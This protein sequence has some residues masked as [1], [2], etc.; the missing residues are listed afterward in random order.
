MEG[1]EF[2]E[3]GLFNEK[4]TIFVTYT[5]LLN[6]HQKNPSKCC[7]FSRSP[8]ALSINEEGEEFYEDGLFNEKLFNEK[9][10]TAGAN[11]PPLLVDKSPA[12]VPEHEIC[13]NVLQH[14][15]SSRPYGLRRQVSYFDY[16]SLNSEIWRQNH[17]RQVAP[18]R[19][20]TIFFIG[21]GNHVRK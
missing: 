2:Y 6:L 21:R 10:T 4:P 14:Q 5:F 19:Q 1:E 15:R 16:F 12:S 17:S 8:M 11:N 18:N 7:F 9:P 3:D 20:R 13:R